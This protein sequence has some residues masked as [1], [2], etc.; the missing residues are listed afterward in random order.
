[1]L[2][3]LPEEQAAQVLQE[4]EVLGHRSN[5]IGRLTENAGVIRAV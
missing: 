4:L 5:V 2:A 1:L 3:A